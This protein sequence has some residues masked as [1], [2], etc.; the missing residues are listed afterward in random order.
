MRPGR[1]SPRPARTKR[2]AAW[3]KDDWC[4]FTCRVPRSQL[5]KLLKQ[6]DAPYEDEK[7]AYLALAKSETNKPEAR[8]LRHP[9][10]AKGRITLELCGRG[11]M[12]ASP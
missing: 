3:K 2:N 8:I 5:H 1:I 10:I 7:F 4:H 12:P 6:G 9:K 11:K